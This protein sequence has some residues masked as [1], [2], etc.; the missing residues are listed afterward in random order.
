MRQSA[1]KTMILVHNLSTSSQEVTL[2][3][4]SSRLRWTE[5]FTSQAYI[6]LDNQLHIHLR[7][8]QYLWLE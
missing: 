1:D 6:S 3:V 7:P 5:L 4:K 2:E 8:C